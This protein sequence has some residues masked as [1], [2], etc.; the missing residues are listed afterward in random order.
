MMEVLE[1]C[2]EKIQKM[3]LLYWQDYLKRA[4]KGKHSRLA[5]T[6]TFYIKI[7][8]KANDRNYSSSIINHLSRIA[9]ALGDDDFLRTY[10]VIPLTSEHCY[11]ILMA[12]RGMRIDDGMKFRTTRSETYVPG[13][14]G[15][16][17]GI[18]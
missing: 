3:A 2:E 11:C 6:P 12:D 10:P 13:F 17:H 15:A 18:E 5:L 9:T 14:V 1:M 8:T 7:V 16:N 4:C